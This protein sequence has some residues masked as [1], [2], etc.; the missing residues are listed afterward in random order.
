MDYFDF[1]IHERVGNNVRCKEGLMP[2]IN[3]WPQAFFYIVLAILIYKLIEFM[4]S[5]F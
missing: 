1:Y 5:M 3:N 2:Q 4:L